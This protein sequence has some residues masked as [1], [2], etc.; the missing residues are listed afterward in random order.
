MAAQG[1]AECA[2]REELAAKITAIEWARQQSTST[3]LAQIA[4]VER[5]LSELPPIL[6]GVF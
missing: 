2:K 4:E 6:W 1:T 3:R 5:Q